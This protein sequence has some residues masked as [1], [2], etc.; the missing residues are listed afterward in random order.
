M[1]DIGA[2][3]PSYDCIMSNAHALGRYAALCQQEGIVPIVEPEV[4]MDGDHDADRC[5]MITE[6]VLKTVFVQLDDQRV[7]L[8][9]GAQAEHDRAGQEVG[10]S[11]HWSRKSPRKR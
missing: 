4:L 3:M 5:A 11:A 9:H 7:A 2:N 1:I 6:W 10:A 8:E